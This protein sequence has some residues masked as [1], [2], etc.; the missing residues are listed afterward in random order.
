M[1]IG[2]IRRRYTP[3]GGAEVFLTRF[4]DELVRQ[5]HSVEIFSTGWPSSKGVTL[6]S[7]TQFG[8]AFLRP[9]IFAFFAE[10]AVKK[11]AP[12]VVISLERT[13]CQEIFR[14]GDGVH[15]EWLQKKKKA[16][17]I[18]KRALIALSPLH[19]TILHLEKRLFASPALKTV[20]A[21]SLM[22]KK[23]IIRHYGLPEKKIC[24]IYNGI[25]RTHALEGAEF[26]KARRHVRNALKAGD[27]ETLILFV[28]SGFE[29]KGLLYLIRAIAILCSG[30]KAVKLLVV[31]KGN[32]RRYVN[33]ARRLNIA[34]HVI[35]NGPTTDVRQFYA[36]AD[37]F[38]LPS[39]YEPFSNA[40]LEAFAHGLAV[41]TTNANG[42]SEIINAGV[43]GAV[44]QNPEDH[45]AVAEAIKPFLETARREKA[46]ES[47]KNT[48]LKY[49][50]EDTVNG[51][52]KLIG[53][54][55]EK[56]DGK[57]P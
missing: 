37:I 8:P 54:C 52:L 27:N 31:G 2:I 19:W 5:G 39:I 44:I 15:K 9:L 23:D 56:K 17:G 20:V 46:A 18:F 55:K 47:A 28:G 51:F 41:I 30:G 43:D 10:R 3:Y 53:A 36:G 26:N 50:I 42:A 32:I 1:K 40:C 7:I 33:E 11:A 22:V 29:R 34:D 25:S 4:I 38:C 21:N 48:A 49:P 24:V 12:D 45:K 6:H 35:F 57:I 14:A 16:S 13:A